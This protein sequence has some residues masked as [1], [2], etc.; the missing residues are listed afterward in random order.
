MRRV[1]MVSL[2][3]C[4]SLILLATA[5]CGSFAPPPPPELAALS[6][7][8]TT[9]AGTVIEFLPSSEQNPER[10]RWTQAARVEA[11]KHNAI[12]LDSP[13]PPEA[14]PGWRAERV[15]S[16]R[17]RGVRVVI[18]EATDDRELVSALEEAQTK[19]VRILIADPALAGKNPPMTFTR[20]TFGPD[21]NLV[22]QLIVAVQ[23]AA[24]ASKLPPDGPA[25]IVASPDAGPL[26]HRLADA[27]ESELKATG[28]RTIVRLEL[29]AKDAEA[30]KVV[31][32]RLN[33]EPK[34]TQAFAVD[35][36]AFSPVQTAYNTIKTRGELVMAG[37]LS[38]DS[39]TDQRGLLS[40]FAAIIDRPLSLFGRETLKA[41]VKLGRGEAVPPV[42][43]VPLEF[44][45]A[46]PTPDD[47]SKK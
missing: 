6:T 35:N 14:K 34:I 27:I 24:K 22:K 31:A 18:V 8:K 32:A 28:T 30:D 23:K 39:G 25:L 42:I 13:T 26:S 1:M 19:G 41:A 40:R 37:A 7:T 17:S 47:A 2:K 20:I 33:G 4:G 44:I 46:T 16:A 10:E 9:V 3:W 21:E 43:V 11:A 36:R 38:V 29:P 5:G 12:L 45:G 15:R